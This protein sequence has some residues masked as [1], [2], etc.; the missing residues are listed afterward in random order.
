MNTFEALT[1]YYGKYNEDGRLTSQHG[2]VEFLTT[3]KY[4]EKYLFKGAR[5]IEIG[6][7][8]GRYSHYFAKQGYRVDAV[9]LIEHNIDI[10]KS[11]MESPEPVTIRQGNATDLHGFEDETYDVTLLLGPMYHLYEEE[12]QIKAMSEAIRVT[13]KGG[14]IFTSYCN[15]DATIISYCFGRNMVHDVLANGYM[16]TLK[17]KPLSDPSMLFQ[18][19][20]KEDIDRL[21]EKFSTERLHYVGTDMATHFVSALVDEMDEKT[22]EIYLKYHFFICERPDMTGATHHMLDVHRK[23]S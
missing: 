16:D 22:F 19:Y 2:K 8:T 7:G 20:R 15:S 9:E 12:D 23:K 11:H 13:K 21:M 6:A 18:L 5:I 1:N 3:V 4:I 14:I 17:F 10:F